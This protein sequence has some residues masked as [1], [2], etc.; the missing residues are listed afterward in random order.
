M[1]ENDIGLI[2]NKEKSESMDY[3]FLRK[4][5]ISKTQKISG[6]KWTDYNPHDPGITILEQFS[7]A[8]TDIAF[9]TQLNI[10]TLLFHQG[11]KEKIINGHALVPPEQIYSTGA[12]TINDYRI[13]ILDNFS[14]VLSNC[15]VEA[16]DDHVE[17]IKGL[18]RIELQVKSNV[19]SKEFGRIKEAVKKIFHSNRNLGEDLDQIKILVPEKISIGAKIDIDQRVSSED[20]LSEIL[21]VIE[22]YFNP[23]IDFNTL[24]QLSSDEIPLDEIY[25]IASSKNGFIKADSLTSKAKEFYKSRLE[26]RILKIKGVRDVEQ[27]N[28]AIGGISISGDVLS[29]PNGKF[30][31][32]GIL[33][34][35]DRVNPFDNIDITLLKGGTRYSFNKDLVIYSFELLTAKSEP[36]YKIINEPK[37]IL[38][39]LATKQLNTYLP[40]QKTFPELYAVGSYLPPKEETPLRKAQ[41]A[42]LQGFLAFFDQIIVNHLAQLA[43][44]TGLLSID[45]LDHEFIQT[46]Y[47]QMLDSNLNDSKHLY[48]K[49]LPAESK[50]MSE[51]SRLEARSNSVS[52]KEEFR[53]KQ[54][55]LD[56]EDKYQEI[57]RLVNSDFKRLTEDAQVQLSSKSRYKNLLIYDLITRFRKSVNHKV[58]NTEEI[59]SEESKTLS[60]KQQALKQEI[61]EL[62]ILELKE[63]D[64]YIPMADRDLNKLM[65][66]GDNAFDRKNRIINHLLTRFGEAYN[67][68]YKELLDKALLIGDSKNKFEHQ[69]LKH[70]ANFLKE[71]IK[72]NRCQSLG[73]DIYSKETNRSS[74]PLKRK[75]SYLTGLR[76]DETPRILKASLKDELIGKRLT[77]ANIREEVNPHNL[78]KSISL[79]SGSKNKVTF[80]VNSSEYFRYL[81][82]YGINEKNYEIKYEGKKYVIYFNPPTG[83]VATKLLMLDS[84]QEAKHKLEDILR[85]F[86]EKNLANESFHIVEHILLRPVD[87]TRCTYTLLD[88][89]C[90]KEL[91]RSSEVLDEMAQAAA[92][93]DAILLAGY[94]N[95]Y[96]VV[97]AKSG[98]HKVL[99]KNAVGRIL[100]NSL[101]EF[102]NEAAAKKFILQAIDSFIMI[103][104]E[105]D[106][107]SYFRLDNKKEFLFEILDDQD[108]VL[109]R[110]VEVHSLSDK[111]INTL[112]L[113]IMGRI[114]DNYEITEEGKDLF[115]IYLNND[116]NKRIA[117]SAQKFSSMSNAQDRLDQMINHFETVKDNDANNLKVR[118]NRVGNRTANSFNH[119]ISIVFPN[120]TE[121]FNRKSHLNLFN[122]IIFDSF[123]AHLSINLVGLDYYKMEQFETWF[124]AYLEQL[125]MDPFESRVD[126]MELSNKILDILMKNIG[127]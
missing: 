61:K 82:Q 117:R 119:K 8:L 121:K 25:D 116:S 51:M 104:N 7:Y 79:D 20:L 124:F 96:L 113:M 13:L 31:T 118:F 45:E 21:F 76:L 23:L 89:N 127:E 114:S 55:R 98:L 92:A 63:S 65:Y 110:A 115:V 66:E 5:A 6:E 42:Q 111:A 109:L 19:P 85:F 73:V 69:Y 70:K 71:I 90:E 125:Q 11:D 81:F 94:Q 91:L 59:N 41:A 77:S 60:D 38:S 48:V 122:K 101:D 44:I 12:I 126:R 35:M 93:K 97:T 22:G 39:K 14:S 24:E 52:P 10:E 108:D 2:Q 87:Q 83:E 74:T 103:K 57:D 58:K 36:N 67:D 49:K 32:L 68:N 30:L 102:S 53:L 64:Q 50:L 26:D 16:I 29:V 56:L 62:M 86:S 4:E 46:Y 47:T 17:G 84:Q 34:Q 54:L 33:G 78:K 18:Y 106:F 75:I 107:A 105:Q 9:R 1:P 72:F 43:N 99:L 112:K 80:L 28:V 100:A 123:P 120:W 15:W 27:L 95:N 40:L 88:E 3:D 37:P